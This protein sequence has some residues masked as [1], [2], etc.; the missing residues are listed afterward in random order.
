MKGLT[1]IELLI[2]IA[3][4]GILGAIA[5]PFV[6]SFIMRTNYETTA[7]KVV[8]VIRKAQG[9]AMDGKN[10]AVWGVCM[11]GSNI[12]LFRGTC[13]SPLFSED[14]IVPST[15]I[16]SGLTETTFSLRG[17][18]TPINGLVGITV[19]TAVGTRT[20]TVN[21]GGGISQN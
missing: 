6:G 11:S 16:V 17:E 4:I 2:T 13:A 14:F 9:Y 10:N 5:S 20:I 19:T 3:I 7:D 12:R 15:V 1:L 21:A 8:S 18:P